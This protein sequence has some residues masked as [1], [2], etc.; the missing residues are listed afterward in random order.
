MFTKKMKQFSAAVLSALMLFS[1]VPTDVWADQTQDTGAETTESDVIGAEQAGSFI[2][3]AFTQNETVVEPVSISYEVGDTVKDALADSEI[4]I[5]G[6]ENGYIQTVED[7]SGN[8]SMVFADGRYGLDTPADKVETFFLSE[9][10]DV[11]RS[12]EDMDKQPDDLVAAVSNALTVMAGYTEAE[13][14][15]QNYKLAQTAYNSLLTDMRTGSRDTL[16]TKTAELSEAIAKYLEY[17]NSDTRTVNV[18]VIQGG[19]DVT[20]AK[21]KFTDMY[22]NVTEATGNQI[23]LRD[24]KYSFVV[25]DSQKP[26]NYTTN[27]GKMNSGAGGAWKS[28]ENYFEV[29]EESTSVS[30]KLASG[31]WF[32]NITAK[33]NVDHALCDARTVV[34]KENHKIVYYLADNVKGRVDVNIGSTSGTPNKDT[35]GTRSS[36]SIFPWIDFIYGTGNDT[37]KWVSDV[38]IATANTNKCS[39]NSDK[40]NNDVVAYGMEGNTMYVDIRWLD[41]TEADKTDC[42]VMQSYELEIRRI[43]T[44]AQLVIKD[45]VGTSLLNGFDPCVYDYDMTITDDH[46]TVDTAPFDDDYQVTVKAGENTVVNGNQVTINGENGKFTVEVTSGET[47]NVYTFQVTKVAAV[48]VTLNMPEGVTAQVYNVNDSKIEPKTAGSNVYSLIPGATYYYEAAK[49]ENYYT[50]AEFVAA[51]GLTVSV[52]EPEVKSVLT[53]FAVY[54]SA[55]KNTRKPYVWDQSFETGT[56]NYTIEVPDANSSVYLQANKSDSAYSYYISHLQQT[57]T[58]LYADQ[59][60]DWKAQDIKY[61]VDSTKNATKINRLVDVSGQSNVLRLR[62]QK[63]INSVTYYQEYDFDLVRTL[64]LEELSVST[65]SAGKIQFVDDKNEALNFDR[66][67]FEYVAKVGTDTTELTMSLVFPNEKSTY[68][69]DG[70]YSA[71]VNGQPVED[72]KNITVPLDVN[73]SEETVTIKVCHKDTKAVSSTYTITVKKQ[74]PISVTFQTNPEKA[75]VFIT[76]TIDKKNIY[77]NEDGVFS[78]MPNITYNYIISAPGYKTIEVSD[79]RL[80]ETPLEKT[81]II[82]MEA[83][84]ASETLLPDYEAQW[85]T[86]RA[87]F[88]GNGVVSARTPLKDE[89]AVLYWANKIGEGFDSDASGCPILVDG[90]LYTYASDRIIKVD[91]I[92]GKVVKDAKMATKS[93]FA[94]NSPTYADGMIFVGL[95]GGKVQAFNAETLES[96]W[97]YTDPLGGQPNC[98]IKYQNGYIYTGFWNGETQKANFVCIAVTDEDP[99]QTQEAKQASW[100]YTHN[101]FYWAGAYACQKYVLVGTDDGASG[102]I[103]GHASVLSFDPVT[104]KLLDEKVLP[105]VGDLRSDIMY[106]EKGTGDYYFTTKGGDFYRLSVNE[107][108]T[109]GDLKRIKLY[110]YANDAKNPAMSTC[111]PVVYNGRAYIGVSGTGQ[112]GAYSGHNITVID[113]DS[114]SIAYTV[115]TQGYPQTSGLLTNAYEEE[116]GLVYVYFIDNFTPGKLRVIS[117]KKGQ[118]EPNEVIQEKGYDVAPVLFTPTGEQA[119]YAICSPISDENGFMYF[120]NDSAHMM[121][122]GPALEKIVLTSLPDKTVYKPDEKFDPEGMKVTAVYTNGTQKDITDY[123]TYS[124]EALTTEDTELMI[125]FTHTMYQNKDGQ[126]GVDYT[127]P[128][129]RVP[130][131]VTTDTE[132]ALAADAV[133]RQ[134]IAM[135]EITLESEELIS[136]V[137]VAYEGLTDVQKQYVTKET[138]KVLTDAEDELAGLKASKAMIEQLNEIGEITLESEIAI[139]AVRAAYESLSDAQKGYVTAEALK[140]LENAENTLEEVI[141]AMIPFTDV[142]TDAYY[143]R[144]VLWAI[145]GEITVGITE[146]TFCPDSDCTRAQVVAFLYRSAGSPKVDV[147]GP[148][149]FSDVNEK[150]TFYPAIIWAYQNGIAS[151]YRDGTFRPLDSVTRGEYIAFQHRAA[152]E[153]EVSIENPFSDVDS[154]HSF[155]KAIMWAAE[156]GITLGRNGKFLPADHC[157][158]CNVVAFLYRGTKINK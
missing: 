141:N 76:N 137:K 51:S 6:L 24:G 97:V 118:T 15:V 12:D 42:I 31:E 21:L 8:Y 133:A 27:V 10:T 91:T 9:R 1:S 80:P 94:I 142:P 85:P 65:L 144:A 58:S 57:T 56:Y 13:N 72:V 121:C 22:G 64:H 34:D 23:Q 140:L 122:V 149:P 119:Q 96:L 89:D 74:K 49:A 33:S 109:F 100:R 84:P 19:K 82:E 71:E 67:I 68:S 124:T 154:N 11:V 69:F 104:G 50:T 138:L 127:A 52:A 83:A 73:E 128:L 30:V 88:N 125:E 157:S 55:S 28:I 2:F 98:S 29:S 136:Q 132:N 151:G 86:F 7:I 18:H 53:G 62:V 131:I 148:N 115:R 78:L 108:G 143:K 39:F 145:T 102:Y 120:K 46:I 92:T 95:A 45:S 155:Y 37:G 35:D 59:V 5:G 40:V 158:R 123:V 36:L 112:F 116:T 17:L 60:L 130:L 25:T 90:Y 134:I 38:K 63:T 113:L 77:A 103:T 106:D 48:D 32:G 54:D 20:D 16:K 26:Y 147:S 41:D 107:D 105:G 117:D 4:K 43:P 150:G 81:E 139:Q 79:Y 146:T 47:S 93:S 129:T 101:G 44:L 3:A 61:A 75:T 152:G 14:N 87:D 135:G 99:T 111:T 70:R 153:P 114:W 110:N 126:V 66:D 156:N